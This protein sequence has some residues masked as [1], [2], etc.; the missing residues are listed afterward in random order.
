VKRVRKCALGALILAAL[1][2][3]AAAGAD[4]RIPGAVIPPQLGVGGGML[5]NGPVHIVADRLSF[6]QDSGVAVAEGNVELTLGNRTMRADRIRYDSRT[7]EAELSGKV[8][9][10]DADEEF[11]FDR[12]TINLATETGV[13]YNGSIRIS[14]NNYLIVSE[15]IAKTGKQSFSIE[16]G[17]LTT[18][19]CDPEPDWKF[20]F[21]RTRV[22][23]DGYAYAKDISF[24][25]RGVPVFWLPYGAFPV[26]LS[27]QSGLLL[28]SFSSDKTK[29]YSISLPYYWAINRW[30]DATL[31]VEAMSRRGYR[32]EAEYR[33][34]LNPASDGAIRGTYFRDKEL[35]RERWRVYGEN[36]YHFEQW[37]ANARVEIPSD[38]QFYVDFVDS[39]VLRAARHAK[40][41]GFIGRAGENHAQELS[42]TWHKEIEEPTVDN[43]LQRLPE[44]TMTLLPMRTPQGRIDVAGNV[45]GG[46]LFRRAGR[47]E[48]RARGTAELSRSFSLYP[49]IT[50]TPHASVRLLG[51]RY[52]AGSAGREQ[53]GWAV[54]EGGATLTAEARKDFDRRAQR[55][56]HVV[57][58][59]AAYRYVPKID[60]EDVP[61]SDRWSRLAPQSQLLL[62]LTQRLLGVSANAFPRELASFNVEWAYD[63]G[64]RASSGTPYVDPLAPFV[65]ALRD[66]IDLGAGRPQGTAAASD[67][68]ARVAVHPLERWNVQGETLFD[69]VGG[70][71][72]IGAVSGEWKKDEDHRVLAEYRVSRDLANDLRGLFV[73]RPLRAV[74]LHAQV[75]YSLRNS[76][77]TEGT[78][79]FTLLPRSDCWSVGL[80]AERK[81]QPEDTSVKLV[82]SL[83]GIG[84]VGN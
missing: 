3:T 23:L 22:I 13:L 67:V 76:F 30:S 33:F 14:T 78:A 8:R 47:D 2:A 52:D 6:D 16:K 15:K 53:S 37:T 38:N 61:A 51:T 64:G 79:G 84:S 11:S 55:Y 46:Y 17:A 54:P 71:F 45:V 77:L 65:R 31:T 19:P 66:Q 69:P 74:R 29:G 1:W 32:P 39:D 60:Q 58:A 68:Y 27:R 70:G 20:E 49:S 42:A 48:L 81:T 26:K 59:S 10:K 63:I 83:R 7:G 73:W 36:L 57:G 56:V 24:R 9:Y 21:R 82:F 72:S 28:P 50:F 80:T 18:C 35:G 40:T 25:V 34:E 5:L 41:T 12:I 62:A 44:Y 4:V 75:N 43:T